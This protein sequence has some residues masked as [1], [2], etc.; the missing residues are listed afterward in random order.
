MK[1]LEEHL[2]ATFNGNQGK[3]IFQ[4][5][6]GTSE[7]CYLS[8]DFFSLSGEALTVSISITIQILAQAFTWLKILRRS[9]LLLLFALTFPKLIFRKPLM[10]LEYQIEGNT[11]K[12]SVA[13]PQAQMNGRFSKKL[14][15]IP[16]NWSKRWK[17][18][19]MAE[20]TWNHSTLRSWGI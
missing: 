17:F 10:N 6:L 13:T 12:I 19:L 9:C 11:S 4:T 8:L 15:T 16:R 18:D 3:W 20:N 2:P 5:Y 7:F 1:A 14:H